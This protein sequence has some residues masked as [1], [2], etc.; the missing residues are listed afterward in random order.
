MHRKFAHLTAAVLLLLN[1][2]ANSNERDLVCVALAYLP[3]TCARRSTAARSSWP[4]PIILHNMKR[5][6]ALVDAHSIMTEVRP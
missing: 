6:D 2:V 1:V 5:K 4:R 3:Y